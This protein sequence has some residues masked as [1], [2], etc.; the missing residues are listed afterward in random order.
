MVHWVFKAAVGDVQT[1]AGAG[2]ARFFSSA[3]AITCCAVCAGAEDNVKAELLLWVALPL[4]STITGL[5]LPFFFLSV[6][7]MGWS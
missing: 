5:S 7:T 1:F 2:T 4:L 3:G 6:L